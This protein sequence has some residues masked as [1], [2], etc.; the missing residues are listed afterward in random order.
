MLLRVLIVLT[1]R[2]PLLLLLVG[3]RVV[4]CL[5]LLPCCALAVLLVACRGVSMPV[6]LLHVLMLIHGMATSFLLP[7]HII[8]QLARSVLIM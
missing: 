1:L 7:L 5:H 8:A 3:V 6:V 4:A 2:L